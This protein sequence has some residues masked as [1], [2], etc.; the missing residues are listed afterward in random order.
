MPDNATGKFRKATP[1]GPYTV[2][3]FG[4]LKSRMMGDADR[5]EESRG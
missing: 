4:D 2:M 5:I 3:G 1:W